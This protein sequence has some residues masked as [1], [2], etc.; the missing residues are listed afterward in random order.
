MTEEK[1]IC[2]WCWHARMKRD[3]CGIYCTG[4]FENPDGTCDHFLDSKNNNKALPDRVDELIDKLTVAVPHLTDSRI[5]HEYCCEAADALAA[6]NDLAT[7]LRELV[8]AEPKEGGQ[9]ER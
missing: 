6:Y 1:K 2:A 8:E 7:R 9:H 3:I 4:G 5:V